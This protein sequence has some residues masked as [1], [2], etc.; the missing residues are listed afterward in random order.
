MNSPSIRN[1]IF[2]LGRVVV[3]WSPEWVAAQVSPDPVVQTSLLRDVF[4]HV[5]WLE[6]DRGTLTQEQATA[7]WTARTG[8]SRE[9]VASIFDHTRACLKPIPATDALLRDLHSHGVP[10]YCLSNMSIFGYDHLRGNY[11]F[12][13]LF[14]GLIISSHVKALKPEPEIYRHLLCTY[15]LAPEECVF[16]DDIPE[17]IHSARAFGI[18]GIVFDNADACRTQL[19]RMLR[20]P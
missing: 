1:V 7:R 5:D 11:D 3:H 19:W 18:H 13:D 8:L 9:T 17:N 6:L 10:L 4:K 14:R 2:D 16:V 15:Q 20:L 12:L